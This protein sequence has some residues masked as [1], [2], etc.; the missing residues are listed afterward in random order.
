MSSRKLTLSD[1]SKLDNIL[2]GIEEYK[3]ME[4]VSYLISIYGFDN[5]NNEYF[6]T[7]EMKFDKVDLS[8]IIEE[9]CAEDVLFRIDN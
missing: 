4:S 5:P 7:K 3:W 6:D 9:F 8:D 2:D 1:Q